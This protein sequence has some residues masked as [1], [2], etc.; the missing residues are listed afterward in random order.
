MK[1]DV[2]PLL[3]VGVADG[4]VEDGLTN[5]V[6]TGA[7]DVGIVELESL[8]P[9]GVECVLEEVDEVESGLDAMLNGELVAYTVVT[10]EMSTKLTK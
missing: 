4:V 5:R 3:D 7:D 8:V 2:A 6:V 9:V 10:S 1:I